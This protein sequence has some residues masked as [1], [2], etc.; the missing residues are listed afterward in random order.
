MAKVRI[1][2]KSFQRFGGINLVRMHPL[3]KQLLKLIEE[4]F[5]RRNKNGYSH[6]DVLENFYHTILCGGDCIEDVKLLHED[7]GQI[8][9]FKLVSPDTILRYL[10][11]LTVESETVVCQ[12]SGKEYL[13]NRNQKLNL[14]L[15]KFLKQVGLLA[16]QEEEGKELIF[17]YDNQLIM[18]EK[19]DAEMTYQKERGYAPGIAFVNGCMVGVE[20]RS[21]NA[22][23]VFDQAETL[24]LQYEQLEEMGVAIDRSRMDAGSYAQE[25]VAMVAEHS[26]YFYIRATNTEYAKHLANESS[27]GWKAFETEDG[28]TLEARSIDFENF[29][30]EEGYRLVIYRERNKSVDGTLFEN[31]KHMRYR[32]FCILTND[33]EWEEQKIIHFYNQR[34]GVERN[35]DKANNDFNWSHL[36]SS[37]MEVNTT[38]M[39]LTGLL[40]NFYTFFTDYLHI[41]TAGAFKRGTRLKGFIFYFMALVSQFFVDHKEGI[42]LELFTPTRIQRLFVEQRKRC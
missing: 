33:H 29:A 26:R 18:T 42:V 34:G 8:P 23:V 32:T 27:L 30:K 16:P 7:L 11:E 36:P 22:P 20:G 5:G 6:S 21:G 28:R 17:D 12:T 13:F 39:L 31:D 15:K 10:S 1:S 3:F 9:S 35:F 37:R 25:I 38:F 2:D 24:R 40:M 19:V 41:L 14:I 4:E